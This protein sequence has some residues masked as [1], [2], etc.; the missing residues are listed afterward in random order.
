MC[1]RDRGRNFPLRSKEDAHD[2]RYFREPDLPPI[3]VSPE[4]VQELKDSLPELPNV[5][6]IRF[7]GEYG[8]PMYDAQ[9]LCDCLLYTSRCV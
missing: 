4:H 5:K 2:Y 9:L 6:A 3:V 8:L 1:I 7:V